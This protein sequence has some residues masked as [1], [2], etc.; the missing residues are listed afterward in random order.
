MKFKVKGK[1]IL[2]EDYSSDLRLKIKFKLP[3]EWFN[4]TLSQT[5]VSDKDKRYTQFLKDCISFIKDKE[6]I[7]EEVK[8]MLLDYLKD[9]KFIQSREKLFKELQEAL[10]NNKFE[11]E[12]EL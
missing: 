10:K 9:E 12:I 11:L 6:K 5:I 7:K 2:I 1:I 8:S 3:G 4:T